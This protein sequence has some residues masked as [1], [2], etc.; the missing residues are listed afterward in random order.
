[1]DEVS[2]NV[3]SGETSAQHDFDGGGRIVFDNGPFSGF[4]ERRTVRPGVALYRLTGTST[5][6]WKLAAEGDSPA[7]HL[8]LG[9]MLDGTGAI[10]AK[11]NERQSWRGR[12]RLFA[13]SLAEREVSY[14]VEA[15]GAWQ[16]VTMIL[17]PG[18]LD[19]V[20]AEDGLP[21][22]AKAVLENGCLPVSHVFGL[23]QEAARIARNLLQ[24]AYRGGMEKLWLESKTME[25]LAHLLDQ[26]QQSPV[27]SASLNARDLARVREAYHYLVSDLRAPPTLDELAAYARLPARR[28]NQGFRHLFGMTVFE[29][30][31]EAR[32]QAAHRIIRDSRELPLKHLAWSVGYSQLS[33]F[34]IAYRRRFGI[35]PGQ[36]RRSERAD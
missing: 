1:M 21:P 19:R 33:N 5:H 14:Q 12:G 30:L 15:P 18:A 9:T 7:G 35:P 27:S 2:W 31:L 29:A 13:L 17:D 32:M 6:A 34:V 28:L 4:M 36:H 26:M 24:P 11:G 23:N 22:L 20:M 10:E 8:V 25:L 16:A 3:E